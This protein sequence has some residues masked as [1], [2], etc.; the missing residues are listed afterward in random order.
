VPSPAE[1]KEIVDLGGL[2]LFVT[3]IIAAG[4]GL[5]RQVWVPGWLWRRERERRE[6]AEAESKRQTATIARLTRQ[7]ERERNRRSTDAPRTR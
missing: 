7:L 1:L 5:F 6:L 3:G 2:A 4:V